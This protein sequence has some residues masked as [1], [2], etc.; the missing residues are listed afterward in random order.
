MN[1][2]ESRTDDVGRLLNIVGATGVPMDH[3]RS[4]KISPSR[5]STKRFLLSGCKRDFGASP[6]RHIARM[7]G[8]LGMPAPLLSTLGFHLPCTRNV[9]IG[10][11]QE[12]QSCI[13]KVYLEFSEGIDLT[14]AAESGTDPVLLYLAYKWDS[15]TNESGTVTR[16]VWYPTTGVEQIMSMITEITQFTQDSATHQITRELVE[17]AATTMPAQE[18]QLLDVRED[19]TGRRSFDLNFYDAGLR[20][21]DIHRLLLTICRVQ[22][23]RPG[24][25]QAWYD[26]IKGLRA[27]HLSC[28]SAATG[29]L[30]FSLYY[31]ASVGDGDTQCV[32][33]V[34]DTW[35]TL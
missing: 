5:F 35:G 4:I 30:F 29:E 24:R 2:T 20:V 34:R 26:R 10:V 23:I 21:R 28:G 9:H 6:E 16:Y 33:D 17:L 22:E 14:L 15:A 19:T 32:K 7:C 11:D 18:I 12:P 3:E 13:Y 27:G 8:Q 31:G 1:T 25:F